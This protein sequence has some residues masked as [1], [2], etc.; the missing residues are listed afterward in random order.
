[1]T[2]LIEEAERL[3][4]EPKPASLWWTST[5]A[6]EKKE[7]RRIEKLKRSHKIPFE[8]GVSRFWNTSATPR[9]KCKTAWIR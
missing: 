7:D 9:G 8:R 5:D 4:L 1:M 6:V 3:D 2:D